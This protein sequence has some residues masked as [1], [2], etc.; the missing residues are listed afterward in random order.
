MLV[1][2][3]PEG[4]GRCMGRWMPASDEL[5]RK[6]GRS[7]RTDSPLAIEPKSAGVPAHAAQGSGLPVAPVAASAV[8]TPARGRL[9]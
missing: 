9:R 7:K 4:M 1:R 8:D 6:Q 2:L 3:R 5:P